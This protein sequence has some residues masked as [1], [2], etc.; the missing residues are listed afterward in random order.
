[1]TAHLL[2]ITLGPVQD[3]IAQARRTRDLWYGSHLLS[4]LGRAAARALADG[5]AELIFPSLRAGDA[6][7]QPCPAPLRPDGTPPRNVA[8]KLLAEVPSGIDPKQ[9]ARDVRDAVT[10][11]WRDDLA[12]PVKTSCAGLLAAGIDAVWDEQVETFLEFAASWLP[13]GD[14]AGT[15]RQIEQAIAG[16]KMLRDFGRMDA[17]ARLRAEVEP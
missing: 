2:V 4:E 6:Q 9:L 12:A 11:Y 13:L 5:G 15:R 1:M 10:R 14:Y 8:N 17:R 16:R 7:L 3:F